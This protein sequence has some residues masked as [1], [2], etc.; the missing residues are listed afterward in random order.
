MVFCKQL[1]GVKTAPKTLPDNAVVVQH[2]SL[3]VPESNKIAL[4][5]PVIEIQIGLLLQIV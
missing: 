2:G 4:K 1:R 5:S 3:F